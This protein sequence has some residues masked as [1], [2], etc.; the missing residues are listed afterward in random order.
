M[1]YPPYATDIH[2]IIIL[3]CIY[4]SMLY[5]HAIQLAVLLKNMTSLMD[6]HLR[7]P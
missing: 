3:R 6:I 4:C 7:L 2:R 5:S 1:Y